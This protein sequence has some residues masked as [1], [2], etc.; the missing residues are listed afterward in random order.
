MKPLGINNFTHSAVT[1]WDPVTVAPTITLSNGNLLAMENG[2]SKLNNA[3]STSSMPANKKVY[4]EVTKIGGG[5][6]EGGV[7]GVGF[8]DATQRNDTYITQ[9]G[10]NFLTYGSYTSDGS[11][12]DFQ[13]GQDWSANTSKAAFA[14]DTTA[15][16]IWFRPLSW[17]Y[18]NNNP[19]ADPATG[20]G[21]LPYKA[22]VTYKIACD[23]YSQGQGFTLN[24]GQVPFTGVVPSGFVAWG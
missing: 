8:Y 16:L 7:P 15:H 17:P 19:S 12:G 22:N 10:L 18:W 5:I 24:C 3:R 9:H 11:G 4:F 6:N 13:D 1:T 23:P 20:V 14:V 2:V 21:G